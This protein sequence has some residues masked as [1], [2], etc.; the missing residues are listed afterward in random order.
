MLRTDL[1]LSNE[2]AVFALVARPDAQAEA[3]HGFVKLNMFGFAGRNL[4]PGN[5]R[6]GKFHGLNPCFGKTWGR[7][8]P[9][10]RVFPWP[11]VALLDRGSKPY[12]SCLQGVCPLM[13]SRGTIEPMPGGQGVVSSNLAA[14]TNN[15]NKT[16]PNAQPFAI[17]PFADICKR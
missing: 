7:I 11:L 1:V 6:L 15:P 12:S 3:R 14:P 9:S 10:S 17:H 16:R 13:S 4:E 5:I 8:K 2:G